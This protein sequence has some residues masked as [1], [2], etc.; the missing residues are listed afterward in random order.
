M[1]IYSNNLHQKLQ[2][3]AISKEYLKYNTP[4][5]DLVDD[6]D[7]KLDFD[8]AIGYNSAI[9]GNLSAAD[10]FIKNLTLNSSFLDWSTLDYYAKKTTNNPIF[11]SSIR[12]IQ[13]RFDTPAMFD[14]GYQQSLNQQLK[15]CLNSPCNLFLQTSDS[16]GRMAQAASTKNSSN[17]FGVG[18]LSAS[19]SNTAA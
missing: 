16:V 1:V 3:V 14:D 4:F 2:G 10:S 7:W 19:M 18:A 15:D 11:A 12:E 17:T 6:P 13:N 5:C 8:L 9:N